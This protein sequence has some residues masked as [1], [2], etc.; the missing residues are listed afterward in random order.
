MAITEGTYTWKFGATSSTLKF[1]VSYNTVTNKWTVTMLTGSMDLNA[2]WWSNDN[3]ISDGQISLIKGDNSLNMNG[4]GVTW[5][6]YDKTSDTGLTGKDH[7]ATGSTSGSTLLTAVNTYG[8][9]SGA[10]TARCEHWS[11]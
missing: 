9:C 11:C 10:G 2:L 3:T 7:F 8:T 5:D 4:T 1:D 6:G